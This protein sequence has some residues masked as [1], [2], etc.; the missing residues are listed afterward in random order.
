M[1]TNFL[2]SSERSYNFKPKTVQ[3][4]ENKPNRMNN[5]HTYVHTYT[6]KTDEIWKF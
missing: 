3:W 1:E 6:R 2:D 5:S 4:M